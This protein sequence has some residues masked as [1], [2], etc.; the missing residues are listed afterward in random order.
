MRASRV[1]AVALTLVCVVGCNGSNRG[2][3]E[4]T[5]YVSAD[6]PFSEPVMKE[7]ERRTGVR[8]N[9]AYD[10]EETKSTGLANRILAES[11]RPQADVFWS[12]EPV[13]TLVLKSRGVL[14]RT[15]PHLRRGSPT[16]SGIQPATGPG[17]RP[18]C[19]SSFT[20]PAR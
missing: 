9:V 20:T 7:Y 17:F 10:T 19:G 6:R 1:L 11:A 4:V 16:R 5:A 13:R 2:P 8:V 14:A 18:A 15:S 3:R 12:N